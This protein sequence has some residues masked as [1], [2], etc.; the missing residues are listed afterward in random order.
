MISMMRIPIP[1]F[2]P[3]T[4]TLISLVSICSRS[5]SSRVARS[6]TVTSSHSRTVSSSVAQGRTSETVRRE[7]SS[8]AG[9]HGAEE[10]RLYEEKNRK[11]D[12][13]KDDQRHASI[14]RV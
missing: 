14:C 1:I 8:H 4:P 7:V 5:V 10:S 13:G 9:T 2:I 11:R 12:E 3:S 6:R